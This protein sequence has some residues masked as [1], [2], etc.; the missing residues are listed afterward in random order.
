MLI[1]LSYLY[2]MQYLYDVCYYYILTFYLK[3]FNGMTIGLTGIL[4]YN[5]PLVSAFK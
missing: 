1:F 2:I 3:L 5:I 4:N